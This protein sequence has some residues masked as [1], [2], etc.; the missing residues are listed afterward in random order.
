MR[1]GAPVPALWAAFTAKTVRLEAAVLLLASAVLV[2]A[3]VIG[4]YVVRGVPV[5]YIPPGGPGL[6]QPGSIPDAV[7]LDFAGRWLARR[8]TFLPATLTG[9]H[10]EVAA[11]VHPQLGLPLKMQLEREA[12]WIK[13]HN[14]S[15][16]LGIVGA[17]VVRRTDTTVTV[18]L[19]AVRRLWVGKQALH[20]T[21]VQAEL[22]LQPTVPSAL[23]PSGLLVV[24]VATGPALT[25]PGQ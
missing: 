19:V 9:A 24:Q 12:A 23:N 10:Q 17:E 5:H 8:Y 15:C 16:Q 2:L 3:A 14:V 1:D 11:T 21:D 7:A 4:W 6:S 20:D 22:T 18:A 25:P 13:E